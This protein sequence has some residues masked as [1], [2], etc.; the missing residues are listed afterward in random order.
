MDGGS[1]RESNPPNPTASGHSRFEDDGSH[2]TTSAPLTSFDGDR[3][4]PAKLSVLLQHDQ[5][6]PTGGYTPNHH[7][8]GNARNIAISGRWRSRD[9]QPT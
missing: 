6:F 5:V 3:A 4:G 8:A 9:E 2:Q 1:V 7:R